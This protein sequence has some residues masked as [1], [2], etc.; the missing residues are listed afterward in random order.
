MVLCPLHFKTIAIL[1]NLSSLCLCHRMLR[2]L[3]YL[4][5]SLN[6]ILF[7]YSC[8]KKQIRAEPSFKNQSNPPP[9]QAKELK[10]C[11]HIN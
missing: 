7:P 6:R 11:D 3:Y 5:H 2:Y 8:F 4:L 10:S 1:T 9:Q